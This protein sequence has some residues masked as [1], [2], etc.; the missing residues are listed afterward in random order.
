MKA[1]NNRRVYEQPRA[2]DLSAA[3]VSGGPLGTCQAGTTP[4]E[5]CIAGDIYTTH[6]NFAQ[7]KRQIIAC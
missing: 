3:G 5:A 1:K 2:R 6:L 7:I 4:F